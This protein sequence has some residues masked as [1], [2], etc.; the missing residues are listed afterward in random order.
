MKMAMKFRY[1]GLYLDRIIRLIIGLLFIVSGVM[2]F[3]DPAAFT[4][5]IGAFGIVPAHLISPLS[6]VLPVFEI[7]AGAGLIID[8][9]FALHGL[10]LLL[11]MF[12]A[13]LLYGMHL[14]LDIDCGCYGPKDPEL[15]AFGG[16]RNAFY[17]DMFMAVGLVVLYARRI[18]TFF[19]LSQTHYS[20]EENP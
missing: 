10:S 18:H 4:V 9:P 1:F 20:K 14:G 8:A 7:L 19:R 17:R 5:V 12:M 16:L 11:L 3:Q 2:K 15:R 6:L 13:I